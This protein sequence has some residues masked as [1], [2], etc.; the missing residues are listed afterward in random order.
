MPQL[1]QQSV[2]LPASAER[3][4][5]MYLDPAE[6]AAFTGKPVT[7]GAEAG[8]EFSAFDGMLTGRILQVVPKRLIVQAWRSANWNAD[9]LDSTLI[10]TFWPEGEQ[11]RID[12]VNEG[13]DKYYWTPW[14]AYLQ[15]G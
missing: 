14:R 13:W 3:L 1:I 7:I 5:E 4:I 10:L 11:G 2:M 9:D 15:K 6:H 12:L 8:S